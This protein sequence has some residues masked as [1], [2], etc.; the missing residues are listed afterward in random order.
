MKKKGLTDQSEFSQEQELMQL[1]PEEAEK[2]AQPPNKKRQ[3]VIWGG[4]AFVLVIGMAWALQPRQAAP[5]IEPSPQP[6]ATPNTE[7]T[8]LE[9][10]L[11]ELEEAVEDA[12]PES[13]ALLPPAVDM[14][15]EI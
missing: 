9:E 1:P 8:L 7:P 6:T 4:L 14:E 10:E 3:W 11:T 15:I 5:G 2:L 12:A 13:E